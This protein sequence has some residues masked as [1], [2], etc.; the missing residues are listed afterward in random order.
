MRKE[1]EERLSALAKR[2]NLTILYACESGSRAWGFP[3]E[4]SDYDVRF[5]YV[6][7]RDW[8]LRVDHEFQRDVVEEPISDLLDISGWDLK[9]ALKLLYKSVNSILNPQVPEKISGL[10]AA[11][12][13]ASISG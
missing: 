8:Y 12:K 5:V 1:I 6:R 2:E 3:S 10:S 7:E 9:K 11:N 4:D 13:L